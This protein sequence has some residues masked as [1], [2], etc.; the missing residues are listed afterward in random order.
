MAAVDQEGLVVGFHVFGFL[1]FEFLNL[2]PIP[3]R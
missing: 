3:G 2:K 1:D